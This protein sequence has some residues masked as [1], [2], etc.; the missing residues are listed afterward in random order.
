MV[1]NMKK[2][3]ILTTG[4]TIVSRAAKDGL[5]PVDLCSILYEKLAI[6]TKNIIVDI[7][8]V[9]LKD[10]SNIMPCDWDVVAKT[11]HNNILKYD[12][13]IILHG[14]DTMSYSAA[15]LSYMFIGIDKPI[16][17]TGSQIPI[18]MEGTDGLV[19]LRDSIIAA[20]DERLRGIYV[21]F[22]GKI[23]N[24][25]RSHKRSSIDKDAYISCN[26]PYVGIVTNTGIELTKEYKELRQKKIHHSEIEW[27]KQSKLE[28]TSRIFL[29]KMVPGFYAEILDY[30]EV[31]GY[32][33]IVIE[34]FGLG[35]LPMA[36]NG[37]KTKLRKLIEK[38]IPVVMATQCV[39]DGV[40]LDTY[41]VGILAK[42]LGIL[43]AWDMTSEA[44]YTKLMWILSLT[45]EYNQ[46]RIAL[47]TDFCGEITIAI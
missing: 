11:I 18:E 41:E 23:I 10:S 8:T 32:H 38:G 37:L 1:E 35:G 22:H 44:V 36:D 4:G 7:Q 29:L 27:T 34:G 28:S 3:L 15:M 19:N 26:Y 16:I 6:F 13:V 30:L 20:T 21:V 42:R 24:G 39:Y 2:I 33:G 14:T 45:R 17:F 5:V 31:N 46:I 12:G 25:T 40:N 43:S 47:E 9:F